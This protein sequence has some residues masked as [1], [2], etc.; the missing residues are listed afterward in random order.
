MLLKTEKSFLFVENKL[1][2]LKI[3][4]LN[5]FLKAISIIFNFFCCQRSGD[6]IQA[7][8]EKADNLVPF[9]FH[10]SLLLVKKSQPL[11]EPQAENVPDYT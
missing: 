3:A 6:V 4:Y 10:S 5:T 11:H 2:L 9:L 1:S 7:Q 8:K